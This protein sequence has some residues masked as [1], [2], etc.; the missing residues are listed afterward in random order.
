M[1]P[2]RI[3]ISDH[4]ILPFGTA[5][6]SDL[7]KIKLSSAAANGIYLT[8][9]VP[10]VYIDRARQKP[11]S[12]N[13]YAV[14]IEEYGDSELFEEPVNVGMDYIYT[15]VERCMPIDTTTGYEKRFLRVF[16]LSQR[17]VDFQQS[18]RESVVVI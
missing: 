17:A 6:K 10:C 8:S 4:L 11:L 5:R 18:G 2:N 3:R 1:L 7:A 14:L 13:D 9:D 16:R 15:L 12:M